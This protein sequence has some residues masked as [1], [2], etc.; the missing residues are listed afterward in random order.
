MLTVDDLHAFFSKKNKNVTFDAKEAGY[1][2]CV[3]T[4]ATFVEDSQSDSET[5]MFKTVQMFH[6]GRNRNG[7]NVTQDAAENSL[8]TI[9]YKPVLAH[10][11][12]D[13][14]TGLEDFNGHE[15]E[16]DEQGNVTYIERQVGCMTALE[17]Y[18]AHDD[19]HD[20]DYV[21]AQCAIPRD[22]THAA[23]II[24]RKGGTDVSVQ[25]IVNACSF[26]AKE[27]YLELTDIEVAGLT[28]LGSDVSP[29][30]VGAKLRLEDFAYSEEEPK[31]SFSE[32]QMNT[33]IDSLVGLQKTLENFNNDRKEENGVKKKF[34]DNN[35][36]VNTKAKF[37]GEGGESGEGGDTTGSEV[38]GGDNTGGETTGGETTGGNDN[39]GGSDPSGGNDPSGSDPQQEEPSAD[40][41]AADAVAQTISA[42]TDSSSAEDVESARTAYDGLTETQQGLVSS[43]VVAA[44]EAQET[45]IANETA[46]NAVIEAINALTDSS[47]AEAV[48]EARAAYDDLTSDQKALVSSTVLDAL[49]AQEARIAAEDDDDDEGEDDG[50]SST[51]LGKKKKT[52]S[53]SRNM[54]RDGLSL[55]INFEISHEDIRY[56]LYNLISG[57]DEE[58]NDWYY[59]EKVYDGKFVATGFWTNQIWGC[60]YTVDG[61]NVNLSGERYALHAEYVTD[62]E[63]SALNDMRSNYSALQE[64]V[65]KYELNEL[66]C[67]RDEILNAEKYSEYQNT[68]QFKQLRENKENYSLEELK[69]QCELAFAA[70]F[71][72]EADKPQKQSFSEKKEAAP[73]KSPK[74]FGFLKNEDTGNEF[75]NG[76][77]GRNKKN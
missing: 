33:L 49:E 3:R 75:I 59:I 62:D 72:T 48:E 26:N 36:N 67:Q 74:M 57:W 71:D 23:D 43:D 44:L 77:I 13:E 31:I 20:K 69:V 16:F 9:K 76:L 22:Y 46:A 8:P 52:N 1:K 2:I 40:Q 58:D 12:K 55:S 4:P 17:P 68:E 60:E 15:M 63:L 45:R 6:I 42:L 73:K 37:D 54:S 28:L 34:A 14:Q 47:T 32:D 10:I 41:T 30:M 70:Q 53:L 64:K 29:G 11:T 61:D 39:P 25:L 51:D 65:A 19:E 5:M 21:F 38:T 7:S 18:I 50:D 35:D 24:E 27:K 56:A 66:N